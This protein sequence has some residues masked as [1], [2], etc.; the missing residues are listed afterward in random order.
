LAGCRV[1]GGGE[2]AVAVPDEIVNAAETAV[3][4]TAEVEAGKEDAV[5]EVSDGL[6]VGAGE[7]GAGAGSVFGELGF[8]GLGELGEGATGEAAA[9]AAELS[10]VFFGTD[11][12][13][14]GAEDLEDYGAVV[15]AAHTVGF[16]AAEE[17][18]ADDVF[19]AVFE[20]FPKAA[21]F[22]GEV[23]VGLEGESKGTA[24]REGEGVFVG[25]GEDVDVVS[26]TGGMEGLDGGVEGIVVEGRDGGI[27]ELFD[28]DLRE[29]VGVDV[30]GGEVAEKPVLSGHG[31]HESGGDLEMLHQ[32]E[33]E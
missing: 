22:D 1:F 15:M 31:S 6:E 28:A 19:A 27:G 8:V 16:E 20:A 21:V 10:G 23:A 7:R 3:A 13:G 26:G 25:K 12:E 5:V 18:E 29:G 11:E 33:P 30:A 9:Q 4:G 17:D 32:P 2:A 14:F 24:G